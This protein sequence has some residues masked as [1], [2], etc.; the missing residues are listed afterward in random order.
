MI[1]PLGPG[2]PPTLAGLQ[3][4]LTTCE[5]STLPVYSYSCVTSGPRRASRLAVTRAEPSGYCHRGVLQFPER[6]FSTVGHPAF[7]AGWA[8]GGPI[9]SRYPW[10]GGGGHIEGRCCL[11]CNHGVDILGIEYVDLNPSC[12]S[13]TP[14]TF[15]W[16]GRE[17]PTSTLP[18]KRGNR[19]IHY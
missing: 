9:S 5:D 15:L 14:H 13:C 10:K 16:Q 18:K 11:P 1:D 7:W 12:K 3:P 19:N 6:E 17:S 8:A 4:P 2:H